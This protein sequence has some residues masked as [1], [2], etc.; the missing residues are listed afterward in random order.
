MKQLVVFFVIILIVVFPS[1]KCMREKGW[2]GKRSD[3]MAVWLAKR[4]SARVA[5]S[6]RNVQN[7]LLAL[8]NARLDSIRKADQDRLEFETRYKYNIIVGSFITPQYARDFSSEMTKRGYKAR[9]LKLEGTKFEMVSAEA[10]ESFRQAID[11][12]KQ[13]QDTVATDAWLYVVPKKQ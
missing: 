1:C 2:I 11:R 5:D 6:I 10:H 7:R 3:T 12:L 13:F 4:D 9:I 8:E